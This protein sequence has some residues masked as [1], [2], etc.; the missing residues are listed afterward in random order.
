VEFSENDFLCFIIQGLSDQEHFKDG[1][2][3][4]EHNP[5][6]DHEAF[7]GRDDAKSFDD[8]QP[9]EAKERLGSVLY[10]NTDN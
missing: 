2:E 3:N 6:Y 1:E 5:E 4:A 8:L 7:L 9:E 10:L